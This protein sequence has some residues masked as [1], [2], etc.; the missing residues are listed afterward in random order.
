MNPP[1]S[2]AGFWYLASPYSHEDSFVRMERALRAT[3]AASD[4]IRSGIWVYSPI[5]HCHQMALLRKMPTDAKTWENYNF[6]MIRA[7]KGLIVLIID[8][9]ATSKGVVDERR[10][11]VRL[12]KPVWGL[13][14]RGEMNLEFEHGYAF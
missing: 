3:A 14:H 9:L 10:E 11:A 12:H 6:E 4:L 2:G 5:A 13:Y 8:G 1:E 7:S